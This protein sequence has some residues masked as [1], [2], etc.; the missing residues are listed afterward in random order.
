MVLTFII[1]DDSG[2]EED[3][4]ALM[5][6]VVSI[7]TMTMMTMMTMMVVVVMMMLA[8]I[9]QVTEHPRPSFVCI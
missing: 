5:I 6:T 3:S 8:M 9:L 7:L 4:F 1:I 2:A